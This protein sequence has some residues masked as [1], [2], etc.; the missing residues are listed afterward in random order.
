MFKI[1]NSG[2]KTFQQICQEVKDDL[3]KSGWS[4]AQVTQSPND[5]INITD[6]DGCLV[7][8]AFEDFESFHSIHVHSNDA[9]NAAK[10]RGLVS[11]ALYC[12]KGCVY[13]KL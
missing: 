7:C 1:Y 9:L 4:I 12:T 13:Q 8:V 2:S 11:A 3:L 10:V 6:K 5:I